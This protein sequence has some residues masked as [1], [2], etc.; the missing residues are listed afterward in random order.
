MKTMF[1][2]VMPLLL[3]IVL[4]VSLSAPAFAA[5][6]SMSSVMSNNFPAQSTSSYSTY[7]TGLIQRYM[8][9]YN[10]TT[11]AYVVNSGGV[12]GGYGSGTKNAVLAYQAAKGFTQDG[13]FGSQ[14]WP[15][16]AASL[17]LT[18]T[19]GTTGYYTYYSYYY[20]QNVAML[21]ITSMSGSYVQS[22]SYWYYN[23][24]TGTGSS[25]SYLR[26]GIS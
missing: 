12:D 22:S 14:S 5:S 7:Y 20:A 11:R 6:S 4:C 19:S 8:C 26:Y 2:K 1:K 21:K 15:S 10:S 18:S 23:K 24:T 3:A 25:Y 16:L 17:S 13:V 9:V